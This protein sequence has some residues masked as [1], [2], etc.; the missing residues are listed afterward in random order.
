MGVK[1]SHF[2]LYL[3]IVEHM[4]HRKAIKP[5]P[6]PRCKA[7]TKAKPPLQCKRTTCKSYPYCWQH[8]LTL[9]K[10]KVQKSDVLHK[11]GLDGLGLFAV[12][13]G[14]AKGD[15]IG[16]Y[17]GYP[18]VDDTFCTKYKF[19]GNKNVKQ[20][21]PQRGCYDVTDIK[22][23]E[24]VNEANCIYLKTRGKHAECFETT[25]CS[26]T[27]LWTMESGNRRRCIEGRNMQTDVVRYINDCRAPDRH[28]GLCKSTNALY[29]PAPGKRGQCVVV[30]AKK[31]IKPGEEIYM[32]YSSKY[33]SSIK[34]DD[35][36][37][38][39][40]KPSKK[41]KKKKKRRLHKT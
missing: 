6:C 25:D 19:Y 12:G 32:S 10:L 7:E 34:R 8:L 35:E 2:F 9:R 41:K 40:K 39:K 26:E 30:K 27:S 29:I 33:W 24:P 11:K 16:W 4:V 5:T 22:T 21:I 37:N 15:T 23:P 20:N 18:I 38:K 31:K 28:K 3:Y 14:F 1:I 13:S 36:R 17:T